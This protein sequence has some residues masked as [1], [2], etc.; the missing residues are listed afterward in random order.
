M[1]QCILFLS[2]TLFLFL[3]AY[4]QKK[5]ESLG[6]YLE[7]KDYFSLKSYLHHSTLPL[8]TKDSVYF[9]SIVQN[10][11]GE[12]DAAIKSIHYLSEHYASGL[13]DNA[14][15]KLLNVLAD[16]YVKTFQYNS[17][18]QTYAL[19][20]QEYGSKLSPSN[21]ID[22]KNNYELYHALKNIATQTIQTVPNDSFSIW[23]D[24]VSLWNINVSVDKQGIQPFIFDSGAGFSTISASTANKL[25]LKI[26]PSNITVGTATE[27]KVYSQLAVADQ[28][29]FGSTIIKNVVFL[30]LPDDQLNFPSIQY[31]IHGIIGFPVIKELGKLSISNAGV[32]T[33]LTA[34]SAIEHANFF[35]Q[36]NAIIVKGF[37]GK[38]LLNF[39]F[40]TGAKQSELDEDYYKSHKYIVKN[41]SKK[42]KVNLGGAGGITSFKALQLS[43]FPLKIGNSPSKI[44]ENINVYPDKESPYGNALGQDYI[45]LFDKVIID[46]KDCSLEFK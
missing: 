24:Q 10:A 28:I 41:S 30:V 40:D 19:L 20:L 16:S 9:E 29:E 23:R 2:I 15:I 31:Q 39:H 12:N 22:Y 18:A 45:Q 14:W 38:S 17:A 11:F 26:I 33:I 7:S 8:E 27:K 6:K 35:Y 42:E 21:Q 3:D 34:D 25:N 4:G 44:L 36:G 32:A 46:F 43:K 13:D 37:S 1:K 5:Y